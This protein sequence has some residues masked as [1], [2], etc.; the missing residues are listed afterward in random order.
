[1]ALSL[2]WSRQ[3]S[4]SRRLAWMERRERTAPAP[5]LGLEPAGLLAALADKS[6]AACLDH[7]RV[8]EVTRGL[9]LP[10]GIRSV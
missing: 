5:I 10:D 2:T 9:D 3:N 4:S 6:A 1:M 7:A 8:V